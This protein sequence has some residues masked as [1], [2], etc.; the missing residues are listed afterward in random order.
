MR[1]RGEGGLEGLHAARREA[2]DG[3]SDR[4][5]PRESALE[6]RLLFVVEREVQRAGGPVGDVDAGLRAQLLDQPR[7]DR[8]ALEA[9]IEQRARSVGLGLG[10]ENPRRRSR[11]ARSGGVALDHHHA[12]TGRGKIARQRGAD[13]P[14]TDEND[15]RGVP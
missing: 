2:L 5:L 10:G 13:D 8:T 14:G 3:K 9:Q 15:V 6:A 11:G 7:E 1:S 4:G 12:E